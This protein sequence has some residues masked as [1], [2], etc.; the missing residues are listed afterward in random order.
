MLSVFDIVRTLKFLKNSM[1]EYRTSI[2]R[3]CHFN[4]L[5]HFYMNRLTQESSSYNAKYVVSHSRYA[6]LIHSVTF[7][8]FPLDCLEMG[9]IM[10]ASASLNLPSRIGSS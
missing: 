9:K 8:V 4:R 2:K 5:T 10:P 6:S 3:H 7:Q 1:S